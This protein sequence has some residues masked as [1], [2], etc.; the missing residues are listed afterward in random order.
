MDVIFQTKLTLCNLELYNSRYGL[1]L[2]EGSNYLVL[3][4][5]C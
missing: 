4:K 2:D 3:D 5:L 1:K